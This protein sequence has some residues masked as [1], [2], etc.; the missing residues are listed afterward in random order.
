[1]NMLQASQNVAL[2]GIA[3]KHACSCAIT[4]FVEKVNGRNTKDINTK[5]PSVRIAPRVIC[6]LVNNFW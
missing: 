2:I 3:A 5:H 1:M 6:P 4:G